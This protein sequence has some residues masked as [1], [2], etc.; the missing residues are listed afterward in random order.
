MAPPDADPAR[1]REA[2]AT[3]QGMVTWR[4]VEPAVP[5]LALA[6][7]PPAPRH[8]ALVIMDAHT[9]RTTY[10][11]RIR[12]GTLASFVRSSISRITQT[13]VQYPETAS[14]IGDRKPERPRHRYYQVEPR[15]LALY[16]Y[17]VRYVLSTVRT[18]YGTV[19]L[20]EVGDGYNVTGVQLRV[21][22]RA[23]LSEFSRHL[24]FPG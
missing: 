9:R 14:E 4:R 12:N 13:Q 10:A 19:V 3:A 1:R 22:R 5:P 11:G 2:V 24:E 8:P 6:S 15:L 20:Y 23:A 7:K 17:S 16:S 18:T 21:A